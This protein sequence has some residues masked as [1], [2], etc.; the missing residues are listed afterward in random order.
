M[1]KQP[2]ISEQDRAAAVRTPEEATNA[3]DFVALMRAEIARRQAQEVVEAN[4]TE[5]GFFDRLVRRIRVA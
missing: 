3:D 5:K 1:K 4:R 2:N